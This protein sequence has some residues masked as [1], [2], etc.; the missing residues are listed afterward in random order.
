MVEGGG[1]GGGGAEGPWAAW[2]AGG[3]A[4]RQ[5]ARGSGAPGGR[6]S[7]HREQ[8]GSP[9]QPKHHGRSVLAAAQRALG[10]RRR[11]PS[12]ALALSP[13]CVAAAHIVRVVGRRRLHRPRGVDDAFGQQLLALAGRVA[14]RVGQ[15]GAV[16][17]RLVAACGRDEGGS[18]GSTRH[19]RASSSSPQRVLGGGSAPSRRAA[20]TN[21]Q[22]LHHC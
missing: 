20:R 8:A 17:V 21:P 14:G 1:G 10:G 13:T 16:L 7:G 2:R 11:T 3:V 5:G 6:T 12:L 22:L 15:Q 19:A 4:G 18:R 9:L